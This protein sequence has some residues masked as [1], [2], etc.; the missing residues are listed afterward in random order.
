MKCYFLAR[1][2]NKYCFLH[3]SCY[4]DRWSGLF[5]TDVYNSSQYLN[6]EEMW[7]V[8]IENIISTTY[9]KIIKITRVRPRSTA[10][11]SSRQTLKHRLCK[12]KPFCTY[13][14][15]HTKLC[16]KNSLLSSLQFH[17]ILHKERKQYQK[18][19]NLFAIARFIR[20]YHQ[21]S[22]C[23]LSRTNSIARF[24]ALTPPST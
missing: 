17:T 10:R 18:L 5:I 8:I 23:I 16:S 19:Q 21:R 3:T 7:T 11:V 1:I 20:A 22:K 6:Y 2:Y 15:Q 13:N 4:W 24:T 12:R 9:S 14:L